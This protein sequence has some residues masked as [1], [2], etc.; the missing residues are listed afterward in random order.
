VI[1]RAAPRQHALLMGH[2][3]RR[4]AKGKTQVV[5]GGWIPA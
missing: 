4:E 5:V 1:G 3:S 2:C